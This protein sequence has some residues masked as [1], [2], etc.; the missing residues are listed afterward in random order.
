MRLLAKLTAEFSESAINVERK[1]ISY[2]KNCI[3]FMAIRSAE[4]NQ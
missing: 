3:L 1:I 4:P 2:E